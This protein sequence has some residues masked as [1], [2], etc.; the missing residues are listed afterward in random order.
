MPKRTYPLIGVLKTKFLNNKTVFERVSGSAN[1]WI[2]PDDEKYIIAV[3]ADSLRASLF[4]SDYR[5]LHE[6]NAFLL[7]ELPLSTQIENLQPL[8]TER[9]ETIRN[10]IKDGGVLT[11]TPGAFMTPCKF[12]TSEL[13]IN[14]NDEISIE[15]LS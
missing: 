15:K 5:N 13:K 3:F 6:R 4:V 14:L 12:G 11:V 2:C 8:L 1:A 7:N 9:G 10:F